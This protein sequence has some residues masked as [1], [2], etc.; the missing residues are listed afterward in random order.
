MIVQIT[1][2]VAIGL[3]D[4]IYNDVRNGKFNRAKLNKLL[5]LAMKYNTNNENDSKRWVYNS[6]DQT[7]DFYNGSVINKKI[8]LK[9]QLYCELPILWN[10]N[11]EM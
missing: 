7:L 10:K 8:W 9:E 4:W 11:K 5:T 1:G 3:C 6:D 2:K